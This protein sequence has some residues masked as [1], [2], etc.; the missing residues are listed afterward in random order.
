M[1]RCLRAQGNVERG[2]HTLTRIV[3]ITGVPSRYCICAAVSAQE[4]HRKR[5]LGEPE[6]A[7][8]NEM[9]S[10][11]DAVLSR[12][13]VVGNHRHAKSSALV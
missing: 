11:N 12:E 13:R 1:R 6:I 7:P 2:Q 9:P 3:R 5:C 4:G 8:T 10:I